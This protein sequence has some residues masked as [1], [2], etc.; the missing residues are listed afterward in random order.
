MRPYRF[1]SKAI[2][3]KLILLCVSMM[4][5]SCLE[6]KADDASQVQSLTE[7]PDPDQ[8]FM[9]TVQLR[10]PALLATGQWQSD[11]GRMQLEQ[12]QID[13]VLAE[14][15]EF[16]RRLKH[17]SA[18]IDIIYRYRLVL[19]GMTLSVPVKYRQRFREMAE[20]S[21]LSSSEPRIIERLPTEEEQVLRNAIWGEM[22]S[23]KFIQALRA[24]E[25]L[26]ITGKG[27][28]VGVIDTGIDY[29]HKM[30][31]GPGTSEFYQSVDPTIIDAPF[32][33]DKVIGGYDFAGSNFD[34]GASNWRLRFPQPDPDPLDE[35][36]HGTHVAG[37]IAG[38][39]DDINTYDGVAPDALLYALKV[40]GRRGSTSD[41]VVIASLEYAANPSGNFDLTDRL[42]V[43][44]LSLGGGYGVPNTLYDLAVQ[45]LTKGGTVAVISAGN[46]GDVPYIVSS[47]STSAEAISVAASVDSMD[48]NWRQQASEVIF[49]DGERQL[50]PMV[51]GQIAPSPV[52]FS[53]KGVLMHYLGLADQDLPEEDRSA[54][55][56]RIALIERGAVSFCEK[57]QRAQDAGAIAFVMVNADE[58]APIPMG[59]DCRLTIPGVMIARDI[60]LRIIDELA[61]KSEPRFTMDSGEWIDDPSKVDR[62]TGFSSRGPRSWDGLFKPEITA[63]GQAIV[64]AAVGG[65][66]RGTRMS[67]T[68]MSGPHV[69]GVA[70]LIKQR[71]PGITNSE[72][73]S[74]MMTTALTLYDEE[75][76]AYPLSRQG[77]GRVDVYQALTTELTLEPPMVSLGHVLVDES[78]VVMQRLQLTNH[79]DQAMYLNFDLELNNEWSI[80]RAS[81]VM[82]APGESRPVSLP[83]QITADIYQAET[84]EID[85]YILVKDEAQAEEAAIIARVP[86]MGILKRV[87][88]LEVESF[89]VY[90]SSAADSAQAF[91]S[92]KLVN[93]SEAP[94]LAI[95]MIPLGRDSRKT[96][97]ISNPARSHLCDLESAGYR[98]LN[99]WVTADGEASLE[100][101]VKL[102]QAITSWN[103]CALAAFI[104][105]DRDGVA[106]AQLVDGTLEFLS[107]EEQVIFRSALAQKDRELLLPLL[108][109]DRGKILEEDEETDTQSLA[110]MET[111]DFSSIALM[112]VPVRELQAWG[113]R[114]I[115]VQL[116]VY[117]RSGSADAIDVLE[118]VDAD[119]WWNIPLNPADASWLDLPDRLEIG[120]KDFEWLDLTKGFGEDELLLYLPQDAS[121]ESISMDDQQS[122]WLRPIYGM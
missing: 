99:P 15:S 86:L 75:N 6:R 19:N 72:V 26:G 88:K 14:Q 69:A 115:A 29:T 57:G 45:N 24:H 73:K 96:G 10:Q 67:G 42:D 21:A 18:D 58:G 56:G 118:S 110:S 81:P 114:S 33:T 4:S 44:N 31:G 84:R 68:S 35:S 65:G 1:K 70:A 59:G 71:F 92:V 27:V 100:I 50:I 107:E 106:D 93:Q 76:V 13:K 77:A 74:R 61:A 51:A 91:A 52:G 46:S 28:S 85:G 47:P 109:A 7:R 12:T 112:R 104:D 16:E 48:H 23:V 53:A 8:R 108:A 98:L 40:F 43:V 102:Y 120:A 63:P 78:K 20:T 90:S 55:G 117:A 22:T 89:Q 116:V 36:G 62:L 37:T 32:P 60:G 111:F 97:I 3:T 17:I 38:V 64:S 34:S 119:D 11:N 80:V 25:E 5:W 82:L 121:S 79:S 39:G 41:A 2:R 95:P 83:L 87:A 113:Q 101:G 49:A 66:D 30:F 9:A 103:L 122:L 105:I 54:V 94:G